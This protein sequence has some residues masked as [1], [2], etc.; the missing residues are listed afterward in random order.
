MERPSLPRTSRGGGGDV[1]GD[2]GGEAVEVEDSF[3]DRRQ[4]GLHVPAT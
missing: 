4:L 2:D 3:E 1:D